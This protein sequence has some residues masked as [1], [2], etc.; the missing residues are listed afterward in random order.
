MREILQLGVSKKQGKSR[1]Y[2]YSIFECP[3]C[4]KQVEKIRKDGL[5]AKTCSIECSKSF[6]G[7][8]ENYKPYVIIDGYKYI[9]KPEH[10]HCKKRYV[11]QHRLVMEEHLGR[12]LKDDEVVHHLNGNKTDND[13]SNLIVLSSSDHSK[14]HS[15]MST[16][17][18]RGKKERKNE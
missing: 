10:P 5:R 16:I 7:P 2:L 18:C 3:I 1:S 6:R 15:Y 4:G 8:K 9:Y 17:C 14:L 12:Y 13:I 11:A